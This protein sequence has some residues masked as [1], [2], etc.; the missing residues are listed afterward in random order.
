[1]SKDPH[2]PCLSPLD[3]RFTTTGKRLVVVFGL[4]LAVACDSPPTAPTW[5][6]TPPP[7]Y[8]PFRVT[9]R[10]TDER[11]MPIAGASISLFQQPNTVTNADGSY[12]L[13]DAPANPYGFG[14]SATR[15]GYERNDQW[16]AFAAE[17]V[18]NFRLRAVVRITSGEGLTVVVDSDDTLY[19]V[20]EQYRARRVRVV[21]QGTGNLVVDGSSTGRPVLLS[22]H[23]IEYFPCCP[24]RLNLAVSTGQEVTVHVLAYWADVP[25]EFAV[26]T[27]LQAT[28]GALPTPREQSPS[29]ILVGP[30]FALQLGR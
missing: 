13:S 2:D 14:L 19:G 10:V 23:D 4:L 26:T 15:E 6:R 8:T 25:A 18:Q 7:A 21:A 1:M 22:D 5:L 9:G 24:T 27:G 17:A 12:E 3:D 16:V 30:D 20:S 29:R 11:G 28:A